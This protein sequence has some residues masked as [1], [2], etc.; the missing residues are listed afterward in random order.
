[1]RRTGIP[2]SILLNLSYNRPLR[3]KNTFLGSIIPRSLRVLRQGLQVFADLSTHDNLLILIWK[4]IA[5]SK[6]ALRVEGPLK[7]EPPHVHCQIS[8]VESY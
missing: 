7:R 4:G 1:M 6:D 8:F 5:G 2:L 3:D